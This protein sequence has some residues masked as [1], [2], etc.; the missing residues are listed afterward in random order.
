MKI[1]KKTYLTTLALAVATMSH[2]QN[3]HSEND[4]LKNRAPTSTIQ[5]IKAPDR[6]IIFPTIK[7]IT[8]ARDQNIL[9]DLEEHIKREKT[10]SLESTNDPHFVHGYSPIIK[11]LARDSLIMSEKD[12]IFYHTKQKIKNLEESRDPYFSKNQNGT[13]LYDSLLEKIESVKDHKP[14][15]TQEEWDRIYSIHVERERNSTG[16]PGIFRKRD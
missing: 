10:K 1:N 12:F 4:P 8:T 5:V 9:R 11:P 14:S 6:Q 2:S 3:T 7:T 16:D 15:I 13:P